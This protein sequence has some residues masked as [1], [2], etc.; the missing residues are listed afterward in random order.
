MYVSEDLCFADYMKG[1]EHKSGIFSFWVYSIT[2]EFFWVCCLICFLWVGIVKHFS[3]WVF[4]RFFWVAQILFCGCSCEIICFLGVDV[5]LCSL[6]VFAM[7]TEFL[8]FCVADIIAK[9]S[10]SSELINFSVWMSVFV[11]IS[12]VSNTNR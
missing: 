5:K 2:L 9:S 8:G 1:E 11:F 7:F 6:K 10:V 3:L 12:R 4:I